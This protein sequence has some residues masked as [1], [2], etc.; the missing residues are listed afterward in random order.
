MLEREGAAASA[1][2]MG[3][4]IKGASLEFRSDASWQVQDKTWMIVTGEILLPYSALRGFF[5]F[6]LYPYTLYGKKA[7]RGG[8]REVDPLTLPLFK[9]RSTTLLRRFFGWWGEGQAIGIHGITC[10]KNIP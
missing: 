8:K 9:R 5:L 3:P 1:A 10:A 4:L 7:F 2:L 6:R